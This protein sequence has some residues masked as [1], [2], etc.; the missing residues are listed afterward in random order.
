M[1]SRALLGDSHRSASKRTGI[2]LPRMTQIE[3]GASL[4]SSNGS[5]GR[6]LRIAAL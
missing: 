4:D 3:S 5:I 6:E 1:V 2:P